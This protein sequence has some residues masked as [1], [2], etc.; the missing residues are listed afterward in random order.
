MAGGAAGSLSDIAGLRV[1]HWTDQAAATGCTVV[2]CDP[3]A[4]AGVCVRGGS[5]GTRELD[6][7]R[8]GTLVERVD[9][10]LLTG[11]S[12]FGLDA[13][14]GVMRYLEERGRGFPTPAGVVPIV[15]AAVLFDLALG[16]ADVRPDADAGYAACLHAGAALEEGSVGAGTGATVAKGAGMGGAWKGGIGTASRTLPNGTLV[17]ALIAVNAVGSIHDPTTGSLIAGPRIAEAVSQPAGFSLLAGTNTTIGV[18]ATTASLDK[19]QANRL[20][21]GA[22]DGL[23]LAI[24]PSHTLYDGDTLFALSVPQDQSSRADPVLL[25]QAAVDAVAEAV[26]RAVTHAIGLHGVPAVRRP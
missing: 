22:H 23:A 19:A 26:V 17:A 3:P 16:R 12:A 9:A 20:A 10:V 6:L 18:V 4:V 5:P 1:G 11:G 14:T 13:A 2:L 21:A 7:L 25:Q 24:R 15:P 8:P